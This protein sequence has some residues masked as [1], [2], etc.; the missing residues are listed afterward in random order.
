MTDKVMSKID[1]K[2]DRLYGGAYSYIMTP[3][4][5]SGDVDHGVL[6]EYA[7]RLVASGLSGVTVTAST[8]EALYLTEAER[9]ATVE[10]VCKAVNGRVVVNVGAGALS[11]RQSLYFAEH[12]KDHGA[13]RLI[14][15]VPTY[16]TPSIDAVYKHFETIGS[17]VD[18][19][20]RIYNIS[21]PTHF[22]FIPEYAVKMSEIAQIDSIK[23]A[24]GIPSRTRDAVSIIGDRLQVY[25]GFHWMLPEAFSYGA[26]GW[27]A[28]MH[29]I[30]ASKC[31]ELYQAV[32][33]DPYG[34]AATEKFDALAP[35]FYFLKYH[36]V[37]QSLKM[38]SRWTDVKLGEP[39]PP[40]E[41][42]PEGLPTQQ[43]R[44]I[45]S[46]LGVL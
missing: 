19:P 44:S 22:D 5:K 23:E 32:L 12:A 34:K 10:T 42:L 21:A 28:G 38:M 3:F 11:T 1:K 20:I 29:P 39:R 36:G 30:F 17:K 41:P 25:C 43:L 2:K 6:A 35:L 33:D 14:I 37:T 4:T 18:L 24:T 46:D 8:T 16:F 26:V 27:E 9:M 15:D 45:L 40:L 13:D 7:E 31:V